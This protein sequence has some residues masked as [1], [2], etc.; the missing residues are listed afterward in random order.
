M[1]SGRHEKVHGN[2]GFEGFNERFPSFRTHPNEMGVKSYTTKFV[3]LSEGTTSVFSFWK[4][5]KMK[6]HR[7]QGLR[8]SHLL[9]SIINT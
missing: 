6:N 8:F 4:W 1:K 5:V 9:H 2:L 3:Y 7:Q